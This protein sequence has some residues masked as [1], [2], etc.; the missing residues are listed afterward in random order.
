MQKSTSDFQGVNWDDLRCFLALA[1]ARTASAA[2][3]RLDVDHTIIARRIRE[4]EASL[5]TVR[6]EK[7]RSGGLPV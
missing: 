6:F 1:R 4:L 5:G 7:S 3:K 2:A